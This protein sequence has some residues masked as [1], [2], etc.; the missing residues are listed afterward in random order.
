MV[1]ESMTIW[2]QQIMP[3]IKS[4]LRDP[5][6]RKMWWSGVPPKLRGVVWEK[7]VGNALALGKGEYRYR[8]LR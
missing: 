6:L 4:A 3:D 7:T 2:E 5:R 8:Y 1:E